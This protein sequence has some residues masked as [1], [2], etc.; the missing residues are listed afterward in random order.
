MNVKKDTHFFC[1]DD[2]ERLEFIRGRYSW[3][4]RCPL[5]SNRLSVREANRIRSDLELAD[6]LKSGIEGETEKTEY[7]VINTDPPFYHV[8]VMQKKKEK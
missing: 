4:Y 7:R 8:S 5:C 6:D 1:G 3:Y 2:G